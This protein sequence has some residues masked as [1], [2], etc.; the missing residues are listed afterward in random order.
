MAEIVQD[1][2]NY[3]ESLLFTYTDE[4]YK[5]L[6]KDVFSEKNIADKHVVPN[7]LSNCYPHAKAIAQML[8]E[9]IEKFKLEGQVKVL[10][11]GA[12]S[13]VFARHF[14]LALKELEILDKVLYLV[15]DFAK[16][17]L[18][19]IQNN[20]VLKEFTKNENYQL[21][22]LDLLDINNCKD[23]QEQA[24]VLEDLDMVI[25]NYVICQMPLTVLRKS[26]QG[27]E[28][29][30]IK[31]T[32]NDSEKEKTDFDY[33]ESLKRE[34]QWVPYNWDEQSDIE[35]KYR[36][37]FEL[38]AEPLNQEFI[39]YNY[40]A[41]GVMENLFSICKD[42]AFFFFADM[43]AKEHQADTCKIY[44]NSIAHPINNQ[45]MAVLADEKNAACL[46]FVDQFYPLVRFTIIKDKQTRDFFEEFYQNYFISRNDAIKWT[47]L[48]MVLDKF[49]SKHS[50][51]T[52][53]RILESLWQLD[54][55]SFTVHLLKGKSH[56]FS[57]EKE[58]AR[59]YLQ[60]A[61]ALDFLDNAGLD[62]EKIERLVQLG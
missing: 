27:F 31:F 59:K 3:N 40:G 12:G 17:S 60:Q 29:M 7:S 21:I 37:I 61:K 41:L 47:D 32:T 34:N 42:S 13:G 30:Q 1:W 53:D 22:E 24:Y 43:P 38:Y 18:E 51:A 35:Q 4:Y 26:S 52:Y 19:D 28:E 15:S 10:E 6:G 58:E 25:M 33:L 49:G 36:N 39:Y 48:K 46:Y 9:Y 5:E 16:Q 62:E 44:G 45:L 14:L 56:I 20:D 50:K 55:Y 2:T 11:C 8:K 54:P 57:G 23:M